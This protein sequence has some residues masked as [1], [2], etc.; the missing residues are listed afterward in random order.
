MIESSVPD[1]PLSKLSPLFI[2]KGIMGDCRLGK[3]CKKT[4]IWPYSCGICKKA[5]ANNL[6]CA[7]TPAGIAIKAS[8]YCTLNSS[9]RDLD[10]CDE[11][12]I[13]QYLKSQGVLNVRRIVNQKDKSIKTGTYIL[14]YTGSP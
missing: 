7:S 12:E 1:K 11:G 10:E 4:A 14:I 3:G 2:Q 6:L 13:V 9:T 8:P 5:H